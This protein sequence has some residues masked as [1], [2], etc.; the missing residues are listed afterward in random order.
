MIMAY[1]RK[2]LYKKGDMVIVINNVEKIDDL[3]RWIGSVGFISS[4]ELM[5]QSDGDPPK[6]MYYVVFPLVEGG[7]ESEHWNS[8]G[9]PYYED[10][11]ESVEIESNNG[12]QI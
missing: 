9:Y 12:G 11:L 8:N 4:H 6:Q 2:W 10:E 3:D 7:I 5:D 1:K